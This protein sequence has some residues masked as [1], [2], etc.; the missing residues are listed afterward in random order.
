MVATTEAPPTRVV[1]VTSECD[2]AY[3]FYIKASYT[4]GVSFFFFTKTSEKKEY[5]PRKFH[6]ATYSKY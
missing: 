6:L 1:S 4:I 2:S 5:D 3:N